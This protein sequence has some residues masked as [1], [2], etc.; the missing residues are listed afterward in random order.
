[1]LHV[2]TTIKLFIFL[3][4]SVNVE[5]VFSQGC[6]VLSH[7]QSHPSVQSTQALLCLGERSHL[8]YVNDGDINDVVA[9]P[10]VLGIDCPWAGLVAPG[11]GQTKVDQP[12]KSRA[13]GQLKS[14]RL[15]LA[16]GA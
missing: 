7:L 6:I 1:M 13:E 2:L 3:A 16:P 5:H 11:K 9:Q 14:L 8:G 15:A 4:T 12:S 10:E